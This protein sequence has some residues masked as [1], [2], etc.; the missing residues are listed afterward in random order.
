MTLFDDANSSRSDCVVDRAASHLSVISDTASSICS[1][2][3]WSMHNSWNTTFLKNSASFLGMMRN[4]SSSFSLHF[5]RV[6]LHIVWIVC[7][8]CTVSRPFFTILPDLG[9]LAVCRVSGTPRHSRSFS[10]GTCCPCLHG[11]TRAAR[12]KHGNTFA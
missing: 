8:F 3:N 6:L 1:A 12:K 9:F 7:C 4:N 2:W 11:H 5:S 10:G